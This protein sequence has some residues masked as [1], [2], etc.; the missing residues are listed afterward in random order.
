MTSGY[1]ESL[2]QHAVPAAGPKNWVGGD[3][4]LKYGQSY[5]TTIATLPS[6]FTNFEHCIDNFDV[7]ND[8]I[9]LVST[10]DDGVCITG[11]FING[12]QLFV[13]KNSD[14]RS[15]WIDEAPQYCYDNGM[16]ARFITIHETKR[17]TS[18][19]FCPA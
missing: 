18:S 17:V 11:L 5:V 8:V 16:A 15:F 3:I 2:C 4:L 19:S 13:G 12:N 9:Q 10:N 1:D 14:L 6:R 7:E